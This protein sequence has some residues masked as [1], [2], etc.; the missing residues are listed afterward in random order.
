MYRATGNIAGSLV[1]VG[2]IVEEILQRPAGPNSEI[3]L[4]Y[5]VW[6]EDLAQP[7]CYDVNHIVAVESRI[8]KRAASD[9]KK[10]ESQREVSRKQ[11]RRKRDKERRR[12]AVRIVIKL[13][14]PRDA[15][16]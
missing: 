14:A 12:L 6:G 4:V 8:A 1:A 2:A 16:S 15:L 7:A 5:R 13:S 3:E 11:A 10:G 9:T